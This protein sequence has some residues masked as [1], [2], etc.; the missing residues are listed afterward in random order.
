MI[1]ESPICNSPIVVVL[2]APNSP[3]GELSPIALGRIDRGIDLVFEKDEAILLLTGGYGNF[4]SAP[5]PHAEYL[6]NYALSKGV[7]DHRIILCTH[8]S[9]TL[10]DAAYARDLLEDLGHEGELYVVTSDYHERRTEIVFSSMFPDRV[11]KI[12]ST[13]VEISPM[14]LEVIVTHETIALEQISMQGGVVTSL[15]DIKLARARAH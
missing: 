13:S 3:T 4:N 11:V 9:S 7:P 6:R 2:G 1:K 5:R 10:E 15:N 12:V 14:E 8:S